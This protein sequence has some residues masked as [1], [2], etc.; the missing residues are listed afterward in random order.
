MPA[1]A[2]K[3]TE[4]ILAAASGQGLNGAFMTPLAVGIGQAV[5]AWLPS[6]S[7]NAATAGTAGTGVCNGT[8]TVPPL[9]AAAVLFASQGMAG[10]QSTFLANAVSLGIAASVT[11]LP[12][13][14]P[15]VGVGTGAALAKTTSANQAALVTLLVQALPASFNSQEQTQT[16][17]QLC[18]A[19][20]TVISAQLLLGFGSGV[21]VGTASPAAAVGTAVCA[22]TVT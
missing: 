6:V 8:I 7:I 17:I 21:V 2:S 22:I 11:G 15:S 4:A 18:S 19:L 9:P 3:I 12:F 5:A 10:Q 20:G 16:Q 14:G 1:T 13:T